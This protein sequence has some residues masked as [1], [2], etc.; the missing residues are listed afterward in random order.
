MNGGGAYH[1]KQRGE[2]VSDLLIH[3]DSK[4]PANIKDV[5][6]FV[7]FTREK[8][9]AV[10]A[11]IRAM[12]K[13]DVATAVRE[14]KISEAQD[15]ASALLDAEVRLGELFDK[16]EQTRGNQ[17]VQ[18][19]TD[20]TRQTKYEVIESLGFADPKKTAHRFEMLA[21]NKDIVEKVKAEAIANDDIPTRAEVFREIAAEKQAKYFRI[22]FTGNVEWYTPAKY[23]ELARTVLGEI[24]LDPASSS[25][26]QKTV[27]AKQFFTAQDDG[28]LKKWFGRVWL[29]PPYTQPDISLFVKKLISELENIESA[30]L[31]THN[32]T[33]TEWFHL[34]QKHAP[35]VCFTRGRIAF[36]DTRGNRRAPTQGQVFFFV[37]NNPEKFCDI[38]AEVGCIR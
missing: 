27:G 29:N 35:K 5:A 28:L 4:L 30:I 11:S 9:A 14:Q 17:Y 20:G 24:D 13:L 36:I 22:N 38:F 12:D 19:S 18:G 7:L 8:L 15:M 2:I 10:R 34:A 31:L 3:T 23:I 37:G 6:R 25:R 26:A 21:A 32:Y 16:I 33:D 1:E